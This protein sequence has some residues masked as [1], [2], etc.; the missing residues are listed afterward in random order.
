MNTNSN[1]KLIRL[2]LSLIK[3]GY[4]VLFMLTIIMFGSPFLTS[5]LFSAE[6]VEILPSLKD[7]GYILMSIQGFLHCAAYLLVAA[8]LFI[9]HELGVKY[10]LEMPAL[11]RQE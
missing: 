2:V 9:V 4:W 5:Y 10:L 11:S 7:P 1:E 8:V 6:A 3:A